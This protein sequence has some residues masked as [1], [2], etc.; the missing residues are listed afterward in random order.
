MTTQGWSGDATPE[1][2]M[3]G[4]TLWAVTEWILHSE[5]LFK[6][7]LLEL[8]GSESEA[9]MIAARGLYSGKRALTRQR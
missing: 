2:P 4:C 1:Y 8:E 6:S 7:M 3:M 9:G 5:C